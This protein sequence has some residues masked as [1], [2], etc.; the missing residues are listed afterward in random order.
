ME[1]A[2][3][4]GVLIGFAGLGLSL[5]GC[6]M[7]PFG[8]GA[9]SERDCMAR[10]MYF[11]SNRSSEAGMLAVGTTVMNRLESGRYPR[12]VCGVVGQP[13]QFAEGALSKR[14]N[15]REAA[16]PYRV[17]DRV[18]AGERYAPMGGA[19]FFHTAGLTFP[20]T[21]MHYTAVAGGNAFYEKVRFAQ[22]TLP[23]TSFVQ[24]Q[25]RA[26][27]PAPGVS[28]QRPKP[29]TIDDLLA[30]ASYGDRPGRQLA[31]AGASPDFNGR[32]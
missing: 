5:G 6:A 18:L 31:A 30:G 27:D 3:T 14:M 10:V 15:P 25:P 2:G 20:Y 19:M 16:L 17:A 11:E 32:Y 23:T 12:T 9:L 21:N 8:Q 13:G 29:R 24:V 26:V 22:N 28:V 7:V 1:R 4:A